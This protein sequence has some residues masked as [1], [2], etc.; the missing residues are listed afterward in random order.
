MCL[1]E[2]LC[3]KFLLKMLHHAYCIAIVL[4]CDISN[5]QRTYS[6]TSFNHSYFNAVE[7]RL[8]YIELHVG[9]HGKVRISH[10]LIQQVLLTI[11]LIKL[12]H[13]CCLLPS[14]KGHFGNVLIQ[15]V[16]CGYLP[17]WLA[18]S[19]C[20]C[21]LPSWKGHCCFC[22]WQGAARGPIWRPFLLPVLEIQQR[23]LGYF[24]TVHQA[25]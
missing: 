20:R 9:S 14:S 21:P 25:T 7:H 6:V 3:I 8:N 16:G 12:T 5:I 10:L 18:M 11:S 19:S 4:S 13:S 17:I 23:R 24:L 1:K 22:F 15:S 2:E